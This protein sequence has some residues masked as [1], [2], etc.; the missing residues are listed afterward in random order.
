M[1]HDEAIQLEA[2]DR[3]LLDEL[4]DQERDAFEMHYFDCTVCAH[5][6][7]SGFAM[8]D[9]MVA[10]EKRPPVADLNAHRAARAR[11]SFTVPLVAAASVAVALLSMHYGVVQPTTR[12]L[13]AERAPRVI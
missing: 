13:A 3:Y 1:N 9:A 10:A 11:R 12:Q 2:S 5:D 6:V 4:S 7:T 8:R